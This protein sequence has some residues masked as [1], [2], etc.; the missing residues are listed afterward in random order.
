MHFFV[1]LG[2]ANGGRRGSDSA[3]ARAGHASFFLVIRKG[4]YGWNNNQPTRWRVVSRAG[5]YSTEGTVL[6]GSPCNK[7]GQCRSPCDVMTRK[8]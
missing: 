3:G 2:F 6:P 1:C 5:I 4:L 7:V 8:E